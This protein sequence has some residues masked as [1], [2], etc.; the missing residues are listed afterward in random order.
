MILWASLTLLA[1]IFLGIFLGNQMLKRWHND[2]PSWHPPDIRFTNDSA[3]L[4]PVSCFLDPDFV[5]NESPYATK[6]QTHLTEVQLNRIGRP[7]K[8]HSLPQFWIY[9]CLVVALVMG[10][11]AHIIEIM[12]RQRLALNPQKHKY[13][14]RRSI[15]EGVLWT[16][17]FAICFATNIFCAWHIGSLRTWT[18]KSGWMEDGDEDGFYSIGQLLPIFSLVIILLSLLERYKIKR[19]VRNDGYH[20][21]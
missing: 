9:V 19:K 14:P 16:F 21:V 2:F 17:I 1:F 8:T 18:R 7:V 5:E 4:L 6:R 12:R 20:T 15:G 10:I 11:V 13:R 3:I